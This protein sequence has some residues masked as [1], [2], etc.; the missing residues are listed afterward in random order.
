MKQERKRFFSIDPPYI[1]TDVSGPILLGGDFS[2]I[3]ETS[4]STGI[5]YYSRALAELAHSLALRET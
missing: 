5:F 1:L 2:Y 3:L 4:E